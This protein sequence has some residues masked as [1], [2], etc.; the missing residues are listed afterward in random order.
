MVCR[1]RFWLGRRDEANN[2]AYRIVPL[3]TFGP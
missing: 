2:Q 1:W 3:V